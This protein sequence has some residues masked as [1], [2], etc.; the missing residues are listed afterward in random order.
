MLIFRSGKAPLT[1]W[2]SSNTNKFRQ[3]N[4]FVSGNTNEIMQYEQTKAKYLECDVRDENIG[5][6]G[7]NTV[8]KWFDAFCT[9]SAYSRQKL[10]W[11]IDFFRSFQVLMS[12]CH[13]VH[14]AYFIKLIAIV[15]IFSKS[16]PNKCTVS[17]YK[18]HRKLLIRWEW[19]KWKK[20]KK[21]KRVYCFKFCYK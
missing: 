13:D 16:F 11:K 7:C 15:G 18:A 3:Y 4:S 10:S 20:K 19:S 9:F 14:S 8:A 1:D 21:Y 17:D 6:C 5:N 12:W 2:T